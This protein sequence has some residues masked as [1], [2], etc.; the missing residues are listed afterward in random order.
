MLIYTSR[1]TKSEENINKC[2]W[3]IY[4]LVIWLNI[5]KKNNK[6]TGFSF[7]QKQES[8]HKKERKNFKK[9]SKKCWQLTTKCANINKHFAWKEVNKK[10]MKKFKKLSKKYWQKQISGV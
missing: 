3:N 9:L 10:E 4:R 1:W 2:I 6:I 5:R 8:I 7:A